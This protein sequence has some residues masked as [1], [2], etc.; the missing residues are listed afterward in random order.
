MSTENE[1][2]DDP[3]TISATTEAVSESADAGEETTV[4]RG[5]PVANGKRQPIVAAAPLPAWRDP[6]PQD[7]DDGADGTIDYSD[8]EALNSD[9]K[10]LRVRM[11]RIRRQLR[12]ASRAAIEAKLT[13]NRALRRALVQQSGGSAEMRKAAAELSCEDL[14]A[15]MVMT[16]QVADE[17]NTLFRSVRDDIENAKVVAYNLRALTQ[18]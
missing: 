9:L 2:D 15:E 12:A 3:F 7:L 18:I 5:G 17:Y 11:N 8:L 13:Y 16:Q 1:I 14:E 10:R 4:G 6:A